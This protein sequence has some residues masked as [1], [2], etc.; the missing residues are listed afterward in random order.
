MK[1]PKTI[2][3]AIFDVDETLLDNQAGVTFGTIHELSRL[4]AI[5]EI[6]LRYDLPTLLEVT[7]QENFDSFTNAKYHTRDGAAWKILFD[8]GIVENEEPD[9]ENKLLKEIRFLKDELHQELLR[10]HGRP[11]LNAVEFVTALANT[12][13]ISDK[14]A[15]ASTAARVDLTIFL[16]ELSPLRVYFPEERVI[17]FEDIPQGF[18]KPHPEPYHRAFA[19][20]GLDEEDRKHVVAFEDDPR[21][22]RSAKDA[23]LYVCAITTM[24]KGD[25]PRLLAAKPDYIME[26]YADAIT[27]LESE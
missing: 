8:R 7:E 12:Y 23:G 21:G 16:N 19:T 1:L 9:P 20:L 10:Q 24:Y 17:S 11:V 13:G 6:A 27:F 4:Q 14:M 2:K 18:S 5:R 22:I 15:I 26:N 3:G 25:D